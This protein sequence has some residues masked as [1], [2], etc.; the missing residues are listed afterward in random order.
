MRTAA[1]VPIALLFAAASPGQGQ[2]PGGG[3]PPAGGAGRP[4]AP[5]DSGLDHAVRH[6]RERLAL[7]P[8]QEEKVR[9]VLAESRKRQDEARTEQD[10]RLRALLTDAQR[11]KLDEMSRG[12]EGGEGRWGGRGDGRDSGPPWGSGRGGI[13]GASVDDLQRELGLD[14][15]QREK[16]AA[17]VQEAMDRARARFEEFRSKGPRG[18]DWLQQIRSDM[19]KQVAETSQ[20]V[21]AVLKTEQV[22]KFDRFMKDRR[23]PGGVWQGPPP[24][25]RAARALDALKI[26]DPDQAAAAKGLLARVAR[27][28]AD[29]SAADRAARD[30]V[31]ELTKAEGTED[32]ALARQIEELRVARRALED[33][34]RRAQDELRQGR[35]PR[36]DAELLLQ[37]FLP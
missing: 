22:E 18:G 7:A 1:L 13:I 5:A 32:D 35:T 23:P 10:A 19:E 36:Q 27:L 37:G 29:L 24:D 11:S 15:D 8:D 6:Y 9:A 3:P 30:K 25:D 31:R 28:Q 2:P 17:V 4:E 20:K 34:L 33:Q 26:A 16:V 12:R 21:K 14:A